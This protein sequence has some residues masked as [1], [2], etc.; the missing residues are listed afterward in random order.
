MSPDHDSPECGESHDDG[1]APS[2]AGD[3]LHEQADDRGLYGKYEVTK[4]GETVEDCFVLEPADDAAAQQA[5]LAYAAATDNETLAADLRE[6][7]QDV[8]PSECGAV[9]GS[10][11]NDIRPLT[12]EEYHEI[13]KHS[14]VELRISDGTAEGTWRFWCQGTALFYRRLVWVE[15]KRTDVGFLQSVLDGD[16]TTQLVAG[17]GD[18]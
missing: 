12:A 14:D 5:L 6:W 8:R 10:F 4:N 9:S 2:D 17:D 16:G 11:T 1:V 18:G 15:N 3:P 7:V 13:L